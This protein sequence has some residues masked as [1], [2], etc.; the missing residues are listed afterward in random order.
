MTSW[1]SSTATTLTPKTL[2]AEAATVLEPMG[3][4]LSDEETRLTHIGER[5]DFL[6]WH[7]QRRQIRGRRAGTAAIHT[8][9][10][11][12]PL[13]S[14]IDKVRTLTVGGA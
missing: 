7:I 1:S 11:E 3:L 5:F 12:R 9:P 4:R 6:G 8:H 2:R 10:S 14:I 13:A